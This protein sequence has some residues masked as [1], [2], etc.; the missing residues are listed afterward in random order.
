MRSFLKVVAWV[1]GA[2]AAIALLLWL[3][4]FDVWT[5][6]EDDP[7]H[8]ASIEPVLSAGDLVLLTKS[9]GDPKFGHLVRCGDP[10]SPGRFVVGRMYGNPRDKVS[11]DGEIPSVNGKREPSP[12]ACDPPVVT[13]KNPANGLDE[14]VHCYVEESA[15]HEH[16]T[17]RSLKTP[18]GHR[19]AVVDPGRV[20]LVSDNRHLHLDSRDFGTISPQSCQ[21]LVFRL[22]GKSSFQDTRRRFTVLW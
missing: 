11:F 2:L 19:E 1:T 4:V 18:E 16:D 15:G 20:Y 21:H 14:E 3:L 7:R 10:D 5:V 9:Q 13:M 8:N 6:H 12:R 22:W 17:F